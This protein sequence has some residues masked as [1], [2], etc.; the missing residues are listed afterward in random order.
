MIQQFNEFEISDKETISGGRFSVSVGANINGKPLYS[1]GAAGK[2]KAYD[3][4]GN[5]DIDQV[6]E[7]VSFGSSPFGQQFGSFFFGRMRGI[8]D[9]INALN[10]PISDNPTDF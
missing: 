7:S 5:I 6:E 1:F 9:K 8:A 2:I 4:N 10:A 3:N